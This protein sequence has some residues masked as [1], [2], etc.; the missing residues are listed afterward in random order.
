MLHLVFSFSDTSIL[1]RLHNQNSVVIFLDNSVMCLLEKSLFECKLNDLI[2]LTPCYVLDEDLICR[3]ISKESL[4]K[5]IIS[6][7]N[8]ELVKMTIDHTPIY[9]WN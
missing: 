6:I 1:T 8:T 5:G 2:K 4:I 7:S 3:G 9:T